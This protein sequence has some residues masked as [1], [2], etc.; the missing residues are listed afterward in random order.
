ME[1]PANPKNLLH[2]VYNKYAQN[3]DD[4]NS[5]E[6][7]KFPIYALTDDEEYEKRETPFEL[8]DYNYN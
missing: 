8:A 7:D 1:L 6:P 2:G 3:L 5:E 4:D